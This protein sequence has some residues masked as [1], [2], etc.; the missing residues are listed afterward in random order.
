MTDS[1]NRTSPQRQVGEGYLSPREHDYRLQLESRLTA[2]ETAGR[3]M[4]WVLGITVPVLA[5]GAVAAFLLL[6]SAINAI[7]G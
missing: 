2:L 6:R 1:N 7:G 3:V 4:R 5:S